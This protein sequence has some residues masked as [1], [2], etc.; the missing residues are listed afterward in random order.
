MGT[1]KSYIYYSLDYKERGNPNYIF[2]NKVHIIWKLRNVIIYQNDR[3][4]YVVIFKMA[5]MFFPWF[6]Y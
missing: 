3:Q 2:S 1:K 5:Q 4:I 6:L